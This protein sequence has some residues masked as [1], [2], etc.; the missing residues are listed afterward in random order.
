MS[1]IIQENIEQKL[2]INTQSQQLKNYEQ[3]VVE[4]EEQIKLADDR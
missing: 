3:K 1:T 2:K 4:Y